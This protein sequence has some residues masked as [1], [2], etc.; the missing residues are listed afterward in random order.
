V[1]FATPQQ[2]FLEGNSEMIQ[3]GTR[4]AVPEKEDSRQK[5]KR[6][7]CQCCFCGCAIG[8]QVEVVSLVFY[9]EDGGDQQVWSHTTCLKEKLHPSV[10]LPI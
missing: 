9:Y 1:A 7:A 8:T 5:I 4:S 6:L 2:C 10:P 3:T